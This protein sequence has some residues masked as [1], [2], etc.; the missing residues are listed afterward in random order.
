MSKHGFIK[1]KQLKRAIQTRG[2][3]T[4]LEHQQEA[5]NA[6]KPSHLTYHSKMHCSI[7]FHSFSLSLCTG[8]HS[9]GVIITIIIVSLVFVL[10]SLYREAL[11]S[12]GMIVKHSISPALWRSTMDT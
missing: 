10:L 11:D 6:C 7:G 12:I 2:R 1:L 3:A 5:K 4:A 8:R 9:I